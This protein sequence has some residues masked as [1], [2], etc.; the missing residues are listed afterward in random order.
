MDK[1]KPIIAILVG[2]AAVFIVWRVGFYPPAPAQAQDSGLAKADSPGDKPAE[3]NTPD[4]SG[5]T[6]TEEEPDQPQAPPESDDTGRHYSE[7]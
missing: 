7:Q 1:F 2:L 6:S 4:E 3:P 5:R